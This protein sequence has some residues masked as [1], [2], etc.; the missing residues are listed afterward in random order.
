MFHYFGIVFGCWVLFGIYILI[1]VVIACENENK[2]SDK[3]YEEII[4]LFY[5]LFWP[6]VIL[7]F[8]IW[9]PPGKLSKSIGSGK[10]SFLLLLILLCPI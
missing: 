4:K 1:G 10:S 7:F 6:I 3:K 2:W 9:L 8:P 5:V